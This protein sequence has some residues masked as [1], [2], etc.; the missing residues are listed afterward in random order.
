MYKAKI[1]TTLRMNEV[2]HDLLMLFDK[3]R[4][5]NS[6]DLF[7]ESTIL[8]YDKFECAIDDLLG[9][10]LIYR[11]SHQQYQLTHFGVIVQKK[12]KKYRKATIEA[13][14][15]TLSVTR[16][17]QVQSSTKL[18]PNMSAEDALEISIA[19]WER[20]VEH[21][22]KALKDDNLWLIIRTTDD[23]CGLC[24]KYAPTAVSCCSNTCMCPLKLAGDQCES[25][26]S[27]WRGFSSSTGSIDRAQDMVKALKALRN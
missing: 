7:L 14:I 8:A 24:A 3:D 5:H 2:N 9:E 21:N 17:G 10:G 1:K 20:I 15:Q 12:A 16:A 6:T 25:A 18:S 4:T 22:K 19:K 26:G 27:T 23:T 11:A 13:Y